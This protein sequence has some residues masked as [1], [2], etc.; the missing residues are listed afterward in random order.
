MQDLMEGWR[1][2]ESQLLLEQ[3]FQK[4]IDLFV[5][6]LSRLDESKVLDAFKERSKA[7][8]IKYSKFKK[9]ALESL[10]KKGID[11]LHN[12][13]ASK[14]PVEWK[15][16]KKLGFSGKYSCRR[17]AMALVDKLKRPEN[18]AVA[19]SLISILIS[20][21]TGDAFDLVSHALEAFAVAKS[22][23]DVYEVISGL[24][25]AGDFVAKAEKAG[26]IKL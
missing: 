14:M 21:F 12:L 15:D 23:T 17:R 6:Q 1:E 8:L 20:A 25:D 13:A 16:C 11:Q 9:A 18:L 24:Q 5:E 22:I 10:L 3:E 26:A 4:D 2:Y 19:V 7:T